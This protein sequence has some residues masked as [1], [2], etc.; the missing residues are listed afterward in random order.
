[1]AGSAEVGEVL[2]ESLVLFALDFRLYFDVIERPNS[3]N[4]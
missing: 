3:R 4:R 1:M 2:A